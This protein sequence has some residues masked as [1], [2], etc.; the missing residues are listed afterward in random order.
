[1]MSPKRTMEV[2][3]AQLEIDEVTSISSKASERGQD[4][5]EGWLKEKLA[6]LREQRKRIDGDIEAIERTLEVFLSE[7]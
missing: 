7:T 4:N 2:T 5:Q 3:V 6:H 1:M